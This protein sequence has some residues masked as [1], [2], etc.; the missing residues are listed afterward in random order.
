MPKSA[1][2]SI[3]STHDCVS[4]YDLAERDTT[5]AGGHLAVCVDGVPW[6]K[7]APETGEQRRILETTAGQDDGELSELE[8]DAFLL[9][10]LQSVL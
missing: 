3:S 5:V 9:R 10:G 4:D 8:L 1:L 6:G 7:G 2:R